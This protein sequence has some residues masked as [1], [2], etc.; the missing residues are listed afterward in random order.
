MFGGLEDMLALLV[1][2]YLSSAAVVDY[3]NSLDICLQLQI[4]ETIKSVE[5]CMFLYRTIMSDPNLLCTGAVDLALM[6]RNAQQRSMV[7]L[8]ALLAFGLRILLF[9]RR[10]V[11]ARAK[12]TK[13]YVRDSERRPRCLVPP[14]QYLGGTYDF[15][16][17]Q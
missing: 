16:F 3:I 1:D 11:I 12:F 7:R 4:V 15:S 10:I 14:W 5:R 13:Q 9:C 6:G 2:M 17:H 8:I